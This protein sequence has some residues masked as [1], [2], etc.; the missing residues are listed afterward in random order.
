MAK[1]QIIFEKVIAL[2]KKFLIMEPFISFWG[3]GTFSVFFIYGY[4][5][6]KNRAL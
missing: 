2:V 6:L 4:I 3:V 1:M 5:I